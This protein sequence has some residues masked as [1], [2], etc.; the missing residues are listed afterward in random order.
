MFGAKHFLMTWQLRSL[1][2]FR[3]IAHKNK[4][5]WLH[6]PKPYTKTIANFEG[7]YALFLRQ[8]PLPDS[9]Q[10]TPQIRSKWGTKIWRWWRRE[11][12]MSQALTSRYVPLFFA[13]NGTSNVN[14]TKMITLVCGSEK[15]VGPISRLITWANVRLSK[16]TIYIINNQYNLLL[17]VTVNISLR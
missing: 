10:K 14:L 4:S 2:I 6:F 13:K 15:T 5:F 1:K 16:S 8:T 9:L 12:P 11:H 17:C 3:A 7:A